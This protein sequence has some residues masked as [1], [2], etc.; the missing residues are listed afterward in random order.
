[1]SDAKEWFEALDPRAQTVLGELAAT[2]MA[3]IDAERSAAFGAVK[4]WDKT[5]YHETDLR[6][7]ELGFA[8]SI[9]EHGSTWLRAHLNGQVTVAEIPHIGQW[10]ERLEEWDIDVEVE[11][12]SPLCVKVKAM[13]G[14]RGPAPGTEDQPPTLHA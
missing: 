1:V 14:H 7:S 12:A 13:L 9:R 10:I 6:W 5:V 4:K 3:K 8:D 2:L 11:R